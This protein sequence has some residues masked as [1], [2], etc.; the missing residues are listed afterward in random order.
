ML[1]FQKDLT[2]EIKQNVKTAFLLECKK[3]E[4]A[5]NLIPFGNK[6]TIENIVKN[7]IYLGLV[8]RIKF[9]DENEKKGDNK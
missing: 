9:L 1:N 2:L 4:S 6:Y 3:L 7:I 8:D 5:V